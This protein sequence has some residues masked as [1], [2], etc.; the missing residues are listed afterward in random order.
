MA[1]EGRERKRDSLNPFNWVRRARSSS[2]ASGDHQIAT[3][4]AASTF[5]H[6]NAL[7]VS[8]SASLPSHASASSSR[9]K[10]SKSL[11]DNP[12]LDLPATPPLQATE[13]STP[14]PSE[15]TEPPELPETTEL[16]PTPLSNLWSR[17]FRE[18]SEETKK[19]LQKYGLDST[20]LTQKSQKHQ[21]EELISLIENNKLSEQND[22]P[23]KI[24]IGNQTI[25]FREYVA[26]TV[27]FIT[28]IGDAASAFAPTEVSAP[29][30][31]AKAVL[32]IPAKQVEHK[33][34]LLGTVQWFARIV[35]R[36]QIYETL[37]KAG[38]TD[39]EAIE[40]LHDALFNV[41]KAALELLAISDTLIDSG[42]ARRTLEAILK[43]DG[44][45]G[46]VNDLFKKEQQLGVEV[47]AC[48]NSRSSL[49]S[50]QTN[51]GIEALKKQLNQLSS[52]LPRIDKGVARLLAK[53]E[54]RELH[55]LIQFISSEMFGKSHAAVTEARIEHTGDWLLASRDF[56]AWQ[57]V[58]SSSAVL[59]LKGTVG[60][61]KTYLTSRVIDYVKQALEAS[62]H[63][64]GFAYFYC[65]RSG[66][67]MQDPI[68][69]LRSFVRQL[70]GKAFDEPDVI[71]SSLVQKCRTAKREGRDLGYKDC[72][73]LILES[74][75]LY[76]K[77]TIILD[78]LDE[79][80]ITTY[81]LCTI[82]IEMMEKSRKPVKIFVSSRP[83]REYLKAFE[84]R[85]IIT[86]D[87]SKQQ[88]DIE[89]FLGEKLYST[90]FFKQRR[91]DIQE[92]IKNVFA[93]RSCGMFR[94]VYLQV[95]SLEKLV[96]DEAIHNWTHNL[97]VHLMAA[98]DQLWE[99]IKGRDEF[100][101][102]LAERAIMWVL[103]SFEPLESETL[104][105]AIQYAVQGSTVVRKEKQTKQQILSLCQDLL[106]IDEDRG[107]WMLPHAS[108]AEY[109]EKKRWMDG[110]C[111][112]FA[113]KVSLGFL[114][115][116]R[117]GSPK[118]GTFA[119]HVEH[120]WA[121]HVEQYD[122]WLGSMKGG[123][124][125]PDLA[126]ALKRF[127]G[128][129]D[130]SSANYRK[131]VG[132]YY[133]DLKPA[134]MALFTTCQYG[135]YYTLR[136]WWLQDKIT[137]EMALQKNEL[138][139]NSLAIAAGSGSLPICKHLINLI[140]VMHPDADK[141]T[142]A[143]YNAI[144][145]N[146]FDVFKLLVEANADA[147]RVGENNSRTPVQGT[148]MFEPKMLQY[149]IDQGV[150]DLERENDSGYTY[151]NALIAAAALAKVESVQILLKA[152]ANVNAAVQNGRHG[153]ALAAAIHYSGNEK[154]VET[155]RLLLDSGADP[156]LRLKV[157]HYGSALEA[158]VTKVFSKISGL[159]RSDSKKEED[160]RVKIQYLLLEAGADPTAV[161]ERGEHGS[162]LAAAA[163]YG[164]K[165]ILKAMIDRVG[166]ERAIEVLRHS[167][168]PKQRLFRDDEDVQQ[169]KDTA[170][171]LAEEVGVDKE[172][173]HSIGL[174]DVEPQTFGAG[175]R[176]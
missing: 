81:N 140:D 138:R 84:D 90:S 168:H 74:L 173:L 157:G 22:K 39:E 137:P 174:W 155:V 126:V 75:N 145:N 105:E 70:A 32:K 116:F 83:D 135:F 12:S 170:K 166:S 156:N 122:K 54:Q 104:L 93:T 82:L 141:H 159:P 150:V 152:G 139:E 55:E 59:C 19:W 21:I 151:G 128:S 165:E 65:N 49:S 41:Y 17:V 3:H 69:V 8:S 149:M 13:S 46:K 53:I 109:F 148:A 77:T 50:K 29:W 117:L 14:L 67:S 71:Q 1:T 160:A 6:S 132:E 20:G 66:P 112:A 111:D 134:N 169:W 64:E 51:D 131:W 31:I 37:Y 48:E 101:V 63:D 28:M 162:A 23:L 102:A 98:Y 153:S 27:A 76:S 42:I 171:Y 5:S 7:P 115:N 154:C 94:W 167:R 34:A 78:A 87:A 61:G 121:W 119:Y 72:R 96:T 15:S 120:N 175:G 79:S 127:L 57:D 172:T 118:D 107:V 18:A 11:V 16:P 2:R 10:P 95:K 36:G 163:F 80:D 129:P 142:R 58:P 161:F 146:H 143:L 35:R 38:T 40:N 62:Q 91:E 73:D 106:T 136:D 43:P 133:K 89:R 85:C 86:V 113:S 30:A 44:D 88:A 114:E 47:Q 9:H 33:A 108:V 176:H 26:D 4:A 60:T 24:E 110:K 99:N 164:R 144:E 92:E 100:D 124:A 103:C 130:E 147:N 123:E 97:P 56:R 45:I 158:S 68:V 125:D 25:I 52:P